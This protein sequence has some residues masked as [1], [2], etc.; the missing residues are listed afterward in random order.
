LN[1]KGG[2][3]FIHTAFIDRLIFESPSSSRYV[4]IAR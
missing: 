2:K 1:A 3:A 4:S